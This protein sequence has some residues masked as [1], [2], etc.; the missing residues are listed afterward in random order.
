MLKRVFNSWAQ[1]ARGLKRETYALYLAM[2]D[3]RMPWHVRLLAGAVVA[4]ALSPVDLIPDF[5]PILG[6]VDDLIL[7]PVGIAL[8]IRLTPPEVLAAAR[9]QAAAAPPAGKR[10][11][12]IAGAAII[13]VWLIVAALAV[14]LIIMRVGG[15]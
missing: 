11:N 7:V 15:R 13:T 2:R 8:V 9:A 6:Y 1:R 5:I 14:R 10:A 4:Y 12:W 3:P